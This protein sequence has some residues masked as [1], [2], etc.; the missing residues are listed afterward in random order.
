[1]TT[2]SVID[3]TLFSF[4]IDLW[5]SDSK[6][7]QN[8]GLAWDVCL[9]LIFI[10]ALLLVSELKMAEVC[11][12]FM[13]KVGRQ[14]V[15]RVHRV[16]ASKERIERAIVW[17]K[18]VVLWIYSKYG[19]WCLGPGPSTYQPSEMRYTFRELIQRALHNCFGSVLFV[20][21]FCFFLRGWYHNVRNQL[22]KS[23]MPYSALFL[24]VFVV[25]DTKI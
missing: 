5:T 15:L 11:I 18:M 22:L 17:K 20:C 12:L 6:I 21:L 4:K 14:Q 2:I 16:E 10:F 25:K 9:S 23:T 24:V 8:A 1:M 3:P 7:E 19:L 13:W